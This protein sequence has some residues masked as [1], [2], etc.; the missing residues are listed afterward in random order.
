MNRIIL[1]VLAL[2]ISL[3]SGAKV[4]NKIEMPSEVTDILISDDTKYAVF[5]TKPDIGLFKAPKSELAVVSMESGDT[6]WTK[7]YHYLNDILI[8]SNQGLLVLREKEVVCYDY[9]SGHE[10]YKIKIFTTYLDQ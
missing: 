3:F 6:L 1:T 5:S 9:N 4:V 7:K 10:K 2:S 8:P